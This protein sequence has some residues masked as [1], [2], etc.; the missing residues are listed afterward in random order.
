MDIL[1]TIPKWIKR[2]FNDPKMLLA[3]VVTTLFLLFAPPD[4]L[5]ILGVDRFAAEYRG[6]IAVVCLFAGTSFFVTVSSPLIDSFAERQIAEGPQNEGKE[7]VK[8]LT[9]DEGN[10]IIDSE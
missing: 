8:N 1:K 3:L 6:L 10:P 9:N 5:K 7:E 2:V 4:W